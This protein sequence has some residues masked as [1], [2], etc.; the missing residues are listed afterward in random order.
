MANEPIP[1]GATL[2]AAT[3]PIPAGATLGPVAATQATEPIPT[4]ATLGERV[5]QT[6]ETPHTGSILGD[7]A[8]GALKGGVHVLSGIGGAALETAEGAKNVVNKVLPAGAQIPD[9]PEKFRQERNIGEQ[10]G[11]GVEDIGEFLAGDAALEGLAKATKV[12]ELADKYPI[13]AKTLKLAKDHPAIAK[14]ITTTGNI[15]KSAAIGG[16]QGAVKGA[17]EGKTAEEA[18][19]GAIGGALGESATQIGAE[20]LGAVGKR[21]GIGT[22]AEQDA[23]RG[24]KPG[25]RNMRFLDDFNTAAPILQADPAFRD[26]ANVKDQVDA[27]NDVRRNWWQTQVQPIIDKHKGIPLN[28]DN[29]ATSIR[30]AIPEAMKEYSPDEAKIMEDKANQWIAGGQLGSTAMAK[31]SRNTFIGKAEDALEHYNALVTKSGY[32]SKMPAERA[33]LLK[34]DGEL[35][36]NLATANAIRDELYHRLEILEPGAN[37]TQLKKTYG[38]LRNVGDELQG[39]VNVEGRQAPTSLKELVGLVAGVAT[40]GAHG[41]AAM[42]IPAIDREANTA[43]RLVSRATR[44]AATGGEGPVSRAVTG[45]ARTAGAVAPAAGAAIGEEAAA[46]T[47]VTYQASDGSLHSVP[48]DQLDAARKVD[49]NLTVG[50]EF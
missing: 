8:I 35:A 1:Q 3:E 4:G 9:I 40:G 13:V 28:G 21:V 41:L 12:V 17:A 33:A 31:P 25:K 47:R 22:T 14:M 7:V 23:M 10:I 19:G 39:R 34:T 29:I 38:A 32:W 43:Q 27:I 44:K 20:L 18:E 50:I 2:G 45:I 5:G 16:T 15:A 6:P 46:P 24:F 30:N 49:P 42:A 37:M 36:G 26:A 11:G 48:I